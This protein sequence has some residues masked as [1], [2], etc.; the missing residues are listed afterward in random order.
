[1]PATTVVGVEIY[2]SAGTA[3]R[4]WVGPLTASKT[5][6]A[7]DSLSFSASSITVTLA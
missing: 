7:G 4:S 5:T 6:T 3:R 2:D 1:M